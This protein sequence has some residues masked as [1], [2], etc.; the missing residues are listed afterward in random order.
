[1]KKTLGLSDRQHPTSDLL[2]DHNSNA[3]GDS[4][5]SYYYYYVIMMMKKVPDANFFCVLD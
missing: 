5:D 3:Y 4:Y 1:M 2:R